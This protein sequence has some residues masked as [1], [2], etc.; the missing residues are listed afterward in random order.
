MYQ[1]GSSVSIMLSSQIH[2]QCINNDAG[3]F[4]PKFTMSKMLCFTTTGFKHTYSFGLQQMAPGESFVGATTNCWQLVCAFTIVSNNWM[5][6]ITSLVFS[7]FHYA[8]A[9][10]Y[11]VA[12]AIAVLYRIFYW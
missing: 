1:A 2:V 3:I 10:L 6:Q 5:F 4:S 12:I 9:T 7:I 11:L 8:T